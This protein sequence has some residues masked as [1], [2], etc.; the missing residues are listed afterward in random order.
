[1]AAT[2][3]QPHAQPHTQPPTQTHALT[4]AEPPASGRSADGRRPRRRALRAVAAGVVG[5]ALAAAA[6]YAQTFSM[7][8]EQRDSFL[9][10]KGQIGQVVET[11]RFSVKVTSVTSARNVDTTDFSGKVAKVAT[12]HLFLLVDFSVSTLREPTKLSTGAPPVLLTADGRR[13]KPTDKVSEALTAFNKWFQPGFWSKG[14]LVF[15]VPKDAVPDARFIFIP[16]VNAMVVDNS[17]PEAE[18][19]LGLSGGAATR[20]VTQP[21]DYHTLVSKS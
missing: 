8:F 20:L 13:Y 9:T 12:S 15:E 2:H 10:Y 4:P 7:P 5:L 21:E 3:T 18:I 19:D 17:A 16:P 11:P 6:V 1:M 14:T